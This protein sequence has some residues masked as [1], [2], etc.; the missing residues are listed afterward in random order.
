MNFKFFGGSKPRLDDRLYSGN[1]RNN[2]V[3][4]VD[5]EEVKPEPEMPSI[6]KAFRTEQIIAEAYIRYRV[7]MPNDPKGTLL[8]S[9]LFAGGAEWADEHPVTEFDSKSARLLAAK[10][11]VYLILTQAIPRDTPPPFAL[12]LYALFFDG[13]YWAD[14]HPAPTQSS[15]S[16]SK[17]DR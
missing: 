15:D 2:N 11:E 12:L 16:N 17:T 7:L 3:E 8:M 10:D 4:D 13:I 1:S 9:R 6:D 14:E 5:F